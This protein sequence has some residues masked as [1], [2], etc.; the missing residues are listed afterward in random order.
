MLFIDQGIHLKIRG[1]VNLGTL[2]SHVEHRPLGITVTFT[3]HYTR[4][5]ATCHIY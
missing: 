1:N 5:G 3:S 2:G 4:P